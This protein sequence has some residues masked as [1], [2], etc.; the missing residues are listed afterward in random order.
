MTTETQP[1][2]YTIGPHILDQSGKW[3]VRFHLFGSCEDTEETSPHGHG[4]FWVNVP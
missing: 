3:Y 4:A 2:V 1:G